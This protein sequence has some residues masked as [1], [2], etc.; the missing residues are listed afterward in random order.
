VSVRVNIHAQLATAD[1]RA[2]ATPDPMRQGMAGGRSNR[3]GF[4]AEIRR[5][6]RGGSG[7]GTLSEPDP[8]RALPYVSDWLAFWSAAPLAGL[9]SG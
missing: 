4:L 3:A 7:S 2:I 6:R 5:H 1:C 9:T 8:G